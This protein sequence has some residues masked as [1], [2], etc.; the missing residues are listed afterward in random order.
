MAFPTLTP[1]VLTVAAYA[2][3]APISWSDR[4]EPAGRDI[5][6]LRRFAAEAELQLV[7]R[8]VP[9]DAMWELPGRDEVDLAAAGI[10]PL[11]SRAAPG[12]VWSAPYFTVQR[13]LL[14]RAA[15]AADLG[16][17]ADFAGRTIAVTRG[18]TAEHDVQA[19]KPATTRVE[20]YADQQQ[21]LDD[22]LIGRID[23]YATGDAGCEYLVAQHPER[24]AV[25]DVHPFE[26]PE[27]FAFALRA[28]GGLEAPLNRF[29]AANRQLY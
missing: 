21:A 7:V 5:A 26:P 1:G 9:F 14:I 16:T 23:A 15:D 19:R 2:A 13:A 18:S 11:P 24:F 22:L 27:T 20:W 28:A 8:F 6:F 3:F 29:I 17:I 10:A 12:V 4:G 25:A